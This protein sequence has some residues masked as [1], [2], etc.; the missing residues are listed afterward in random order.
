MKFALIG[1]GTP[2]RPNVTLT[3]VP[4]VPVSES[5]TCVI[6]QPCVDSGADLDDVV[7]FANAAG[8]GRRVRIDRARP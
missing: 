4:G 5:E 7:A 6:V 8:F 1:V 2:G 3:F